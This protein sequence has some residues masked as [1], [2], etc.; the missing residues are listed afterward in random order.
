MRRS[1]AVLAA[2]MLT[3]PVLAQLPDAASDGAPPAPPVK[4]KK[5]CHPIDS[6]NPLQLLVKCHE[7]P[8]ETAAK[9]MKTKGKASTTEVAQNASPH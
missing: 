7:V 3:G 4:M 2:L 9:D 6:G 5:V 1:L 8:V